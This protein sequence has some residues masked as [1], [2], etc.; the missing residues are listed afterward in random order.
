MKLLKAVEVLDDILH[1]VSP[2]DPPDEHDALKL[3]I[4][5][6]KRINQYRLADHMIEEDLLPGETDE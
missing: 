2:G 4:E 3:G 1:Y 6:L 5:A